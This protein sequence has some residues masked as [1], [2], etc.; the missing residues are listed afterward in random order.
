MDDG[1]PVAQALGLVEVVGRQQDGHAR[2]RAQ[3]VDDVEQLMPDAGVEPHCRLVEEEH[4]RFRQQR[5]EDLKPPALAAAVGAHGPVENL[6]QPEGGSE[7]RHARG[8]GS[9]GYSP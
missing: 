6:G 9:P 4:G 7:L 1:D 3:L 5:A 8:G 2:T